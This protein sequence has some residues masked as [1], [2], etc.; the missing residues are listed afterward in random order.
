M[1]VSGT[2]RVNTA[3]SSLWLDV[4]YQ[5]ADPDIAGNF[6]L[7]T[8]SL[9]LR[10][11]GLWV[12]SGTDDCRVWAGTT[13][14]SWTGPSIYDTNIGVVDLGSCTL[15][16]PHDPDGTWT[17]KIGGSW[18]L[19]I[20][21]GGTYIGTISGEKEVTLTPIARASQVSVSA[22]TA[23]MLQEIEIRT[24]RASSAFTHTLSY[25]FGGKAG[26][27]GDNIGEKISWVPPDLSDCCSNAV[28]GECTLTCV[29][30]NGSA[31]IG[32]STKKITLNVPDPVTPEI[33]TA[34]PTMGSPVSIRLPN[35]AKNFTL[36]VTFVFGTASGSIST[37][38]I[39]SCEWVPDYALAKEMP[40]AVTGNGIIR[41]VSKNGTAVVGQKQAVLS[42]SV[43]DNA[44]TKPKIT[45]ATI[46]PFSTLPEAFAGLYLRY[47]N[48]VQAE[49]TAESAYSQI[50]GYSI[51]V[52]GKTYTGDPAISDLLTTAGECRVVVTATD[53]RGFS[54]S[55]ERTIQVL[56]YSFPQV[57]PYKGENS[58]LCRRARADGTADSGGIYL[59]IKAGR[60][61]APCTADGVQKNFCV[62]RY[63]IRSASA[64]TFPDWV[65]LLPAADT[66]TD[67]V[68]LLRPSPTLDVSASYVVQISVMDTTLSGPDPLE[69][70]IGTD[71]VQL[72]LRPDGNGIGVGKYGEEAG[73]ADFGYP[74]RM[75]G[76]KVHGLGDATED[77]DALTL[78]GMKAYL[79]DFLQI[80]HEKEHPVGSFYFS[81]DPTDP[82]ELFGGVWKAVGGRVLVGTGLN[83]ANTKAWFGEDDFRAGTINIPVG[84]MGGCTR[85]ILTELEMPSHTHSAAVNGGT[86]DYGR[87]R[88]SIGNFAI[89]TQ[90]YTDG[91]TVIASGGSRAHN[92]MPPYL[93][94]YMWQRTK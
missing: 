54:A 67:N 48:G 73:E 8:V 15:K 35:R 74:I 51:Q 24:N 60:S 17:G 11:G 42:L 30:Y 40:E 37:G 79:K 1:G 65:T 3:A 10:H 21:Y 44:Q 69:F 75:N 47:R 85:H 4:R 23:T 68:L 84:T 14:Q 22:D 33:L 57:V 2:F 38:K 53:K 56:P 93:A 28:S 76:H 26:T 71:D 46:S 63:R 18:R 31:K 39:G 62:L 92:N 72:H 77:S 70:F 66:S 55:E 82:S 59:S 43:P 94:V 91:S 12:G 20:T 80:I 32:S 88:T 86:D 58:I 78:G 6:S 9:S 61:Y 64:E 41:C 19:G 90:G 83:E 16:V 81:M 45:G 87:S 89:K 5:E 13:G 25:T 50:A 34:S 52:E 7:V 29:T 36:E 49:V 27:I